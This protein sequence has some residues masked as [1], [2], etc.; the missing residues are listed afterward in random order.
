VRRSRIVV[1]LDKGLGWT[2]P[3]VRRRLRRLRHTELARHRDQI[4][5][6]RAAGRQRCPVCGTRT[7][8][9][10]PASTSPTT[11]LALARGPP[12]QA[13]GAP[14]SSS[15]PTHRKKVNPCPHPAPG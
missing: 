6:I 13:A 7:A 3:G 8:R 5:A 10:L 9:R 2:G 12:P 4:T 14:A 15:A 11:D 1:H